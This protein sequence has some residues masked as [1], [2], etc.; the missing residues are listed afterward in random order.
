LYQVRRRMLQFA[1]NPHGDP[2]FWQPA[3]LLQKLAESGGTFN[4]GE[5]VPA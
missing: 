3:P 1:R 2:G 4:G 5:G